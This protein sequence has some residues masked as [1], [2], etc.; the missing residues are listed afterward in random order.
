MKGNR[1][2]YTSFSNDSLREGYLPDHLFR[3][4]AIMESH[5]GSA[6]RAVVKL[7]TIAYEMGKNRRAAERA[8]KWF[9]RNSNLQA[10]KRGYLYEFYTEPD[11]SVLYGQTRVSHVVVHPDTFTKITKEKDLY[12]NPKEVF[13]NKWEKSGKPPELS[14]EEK[15]LVENIVKWVM[16]PMFKTWLPEKV[17]KYRAIGAI[18][19]YGYAAILKIYK[20]E[21]EWGLS[22]HPKPFWERIKELDNMA[23]TPK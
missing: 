14:G 22:P 6:G 17:E 1:R 20:E 23:Q 21:A 7:E 5:L 3:F 18:R 4:R 11:R 10:K 9:L 13:S 16:N 8:K 15:V 2:G 12:K 19:K